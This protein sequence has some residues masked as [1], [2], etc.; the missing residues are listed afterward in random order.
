MEPGSVGLED[1][2]KRSSTGEQEVVCKRKSQD[3]STYSVTIEQLKRCLLQVYTLAD[4]ILLPVGGS[5]SSIVFSTGAK[6][7]FPVNTITHE[8]LHLA[9]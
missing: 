1:D 5:D 8:L 7:F 9:W 4:R 6:I 3:G 2:G